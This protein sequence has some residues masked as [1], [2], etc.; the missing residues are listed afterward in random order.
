MTVRG[1]AEVLFEPGRDDEW[2]DLR[3]PLPD[4]GVT[5]PLP[6]CTDGTQEWRYD[7]AYRM[8]THDEP[9]ALVAVPVDGSRVTPGAMPVLGEYLDGSWAPRYYRD[10]PPRFVVSQVGRALRDVRVVEG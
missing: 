2:R 8:M 3:L 4:A 9:R 1:R 10:T 7:E 5:G 6:R